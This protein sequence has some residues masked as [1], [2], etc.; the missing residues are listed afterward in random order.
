MPPAKRSCSTLAGRDW[1]LCVDPHPDGTV[2][3]TI[4][5]IQ[6]VLLWEVRQELKQ[7]NRLLHCPNFTGLPAT[8][9]RIARNTA[10]PKRRKA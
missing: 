10:T 5:R 2:T 6:A 7:L 9:R 8:L 3:A 1:R 4:D